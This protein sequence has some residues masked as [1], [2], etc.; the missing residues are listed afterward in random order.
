MFRR[1][2][3]YLAYLYLSLVKWTTRLE[4]LGE[5][6]RAL[7]RAKN[8][9]FIYA[10]WH[11][12]QMFFTT[13]HRG[14]NLSV[15][16]SLSRDGEM[17]AKVMSLS[18]IRASRGSSSK[19]ASAALK[20]MMRLTEE[21]WDLGITPD[22]PKGPKEEVKRGGVFL[23]Q[24]LGIPILPTA[25]F[26]SRK[27]VL[28]RSWDQYQVPLPCGRAAIAYG[29]PVWVGPDDDL[30]LKARELAEELSRASLEAQ[31]RVQSS[32]AGFR[33]KG[34]LFLENLLFAPLALFFIFKFLFSSRRRI[35]LGLKDEI[36]ERLGFVNLAR[37]KDSLPHP[38]IWVHAS[39]AGEVSSVE[40]LIGLIKAQY[41]QFLIAMTS[42]NAQGKIRAQKLNL[43]DFHLMAPLDFFPAVRRFLRR[44]RPDALILVE[45]ELWPHLIAL[46][47][48]RKI[49]VI[50]VSAA[51]SQRSFWRYQKLSF[52]VKPFL[53]RIALIAVQTDADAE[54]FKKLGADPEKVF[55]SGSL[56]Y[57]RNRERDHS[58]AQEA[59]QTLNW[60]KERFWVAAST[61]LKEEEI[62]IESF[63]QLRQKGGGLKL[64][65]APR[66]IERVRELE[67]LLQKK[68]VSFIAYSKMK[69][70]VPQERDCLILDRLGIL[71]GFYR[72]AVLTFVGGT[73]IPMGGHSLIE[74]AL[75]KSPV[76]FGPSVDSSAELARVLVS[77]GA[78]F[79]LRDAE[80][81]TSCLNLLAEDSVRL[82][83]AREAAQSSAQGFCGASTR[84]LEALKKRRLTPFL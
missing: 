53:K 79:E 2:A 60:A 69:N 63:L 29:K 43:A 26:L 58:L 55:V 83:Q 45:T 47:F 34:V 81:L 33:V 64:V 84:T 78:G 40:P 1:A 16:V 4:T 51:L 82:S 57:D 72:G 9:R 74:P 17:I 18:K 8:Q 48:S 70:E 27:I 3:P 65:I 24:K 75:E 76:A 73:L 44:A 54:R 50:L 39:S 68:G 49:P 35:L 11:N 67:E 30:D 28:R 71:A 77:K 12:Q 13:S 5:E 61:H 19:N 46:P 15:L 25:N 66:H 22:G 52:L 80:S 38:L 37:K 21:G 14:D 23:A 31:D 59:L 6:K 20:E 32:V 7:L 42:T 10:F 41:P 36:K 56:K 62:L